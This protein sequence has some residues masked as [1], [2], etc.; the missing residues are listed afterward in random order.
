MKY[1][2]VNSRI[3]E[4]IGGR[5]ETSPASVRAMCVM[6]RIT[7]R[8]KDEGGDCDPSIV[9][10]NPIVNDDVVEIFHRARQRMDAPQPMEQKAKRDWWWAVKF[11]S[12]LIIALPIT[13]CLNQKQPETPEQKLNRE[14]REGQR[15]VCEKWGK[16]VEG[17]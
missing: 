15:A 9:D 1:E 5:F 13:Y 12:L 2:F 10:P 14:I 3:A 7:Y 8:K 4:E 16:M 11:L 6:A 17:C